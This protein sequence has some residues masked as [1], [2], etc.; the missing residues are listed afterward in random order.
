MS[1]KTTVLILVALAAVITIF[2]LFLLKGAEFEGSD[3]QGSEMVEEIMGDE[4]EPWFEPILETLIGGELPGEMESLFFCI[5]TGIGVGII[6]Y[7]FGYL[8]ARKKYSTEVEDSSFV[9]KDAAAQ[10]V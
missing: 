5:Q 9:S 1:K 2:P 3:G 8:V 7:S 6:A 10:S 4:Y